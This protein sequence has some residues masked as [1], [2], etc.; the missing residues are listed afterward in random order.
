[1]GGQRRANTHLFLAS[2]LDVFMAL[3]MGA[4]SLLMVAPAR[5]VMRDSSRRSSKPGRLPV[6]HSGMATS[7]AMGTASFQSYMA[8]HRKPASSTS[9][10]FTLTCRY[11]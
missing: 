11:L 8:F 4:T 10:G 3:N 6:I 1:M 5:M 9:L 7:S 2:K